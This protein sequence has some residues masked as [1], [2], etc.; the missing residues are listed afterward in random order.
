MKGHV[1]S[2]TMN[3]M[4]MTDIN[5]LPSERVIVPEAW[6]MNDKERRRI[7]MDIATQVVEE[8]VIFLSTF[9]PIMESVE[10][11]ILIMC[12]IMPVKCLV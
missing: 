5:D 3:R 8:N 10:K 2:C 6:M 7:L 12:T 11:W 1:I 9:C 4:G